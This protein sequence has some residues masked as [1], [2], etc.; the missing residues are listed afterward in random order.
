MN[1]SVMVNPGALSEESAVFV[2]GNDPAAKAQVGEIL[3][4]WFGWRQ[5]VDLGD[6]STARGAEMIL[7]L[8]VKL[9]EAMGTARFNFRLVT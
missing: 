6:L 9:R 7:P 4:E 5:V 8:W 3:R 2:S 1:A